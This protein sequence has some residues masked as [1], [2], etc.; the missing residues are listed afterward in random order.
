MS[1]V[2]SPAHA[3]APRALLRRRCAVCGDKR[4][5]PVAPPK[6]EARLLRCN[7]CGVVYWDGAWTA[8]HVQEYYQTYY[9]CEEPARYDPLTERRYHAILQRI[10]RRAPPGRLLE[11]GC[12]AGHFL[13]VAQTRGWQTTGL[14]VSG[15]ALQLLR[16]LQSQGGLRS[17]VIDQELS[18]ARLPSAA[19]DAVVMIEVLEHLD[20][21]LTTLQDVHRLLRDDGVL[22]LTTPNYD[23]LSRRLLGA[24]WRIIAEEHRCLFTPK[25]LRQCLAR[26]GFRPANLTTKNLDLPDLLATWGLRRGDGHPTHERSGSQRCRRYVEQ[27]AWLRGLK[28]GINGIL[29]L[30]SAGD[31]IE[32]TA[33]KKDAPIGPDA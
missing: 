17:T 30:L 10:E 9:R 1:T 22:Y 28:Q 14:E 21:P 4:A 29:R 33:E 8:A 20:E 15:S 11:I 16:H 3:T 12:G 19:F 27:T 25:A 24:R 18:Q 26:S 7:H 31:T 5:R 2:V 6:P 32:L 13:S 23:S